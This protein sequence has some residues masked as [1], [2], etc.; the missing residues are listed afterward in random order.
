MHPCRQ[1]VSAHRPHA[2]EET[3]A[4]TAISGVSPQHASLQIVRMNQLVFVTHLIGS[5]SSL[6]SLWRILMPLFLARGH[7]DRLE[8]R[9]NSCG[10]QANTPPCVL[11]AVHPTSCE[12][13]SFP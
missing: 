2:K 5:W 3:E 13:R 1:K 12:R 6:S 4:A 10:P 7:P 9:Q 8:D 11:A